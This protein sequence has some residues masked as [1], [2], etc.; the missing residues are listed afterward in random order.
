MT[1]KS[2]RSDLLRPD[3]M[4]LIAF[5]ATVFAG[6]VTFMT[7]GGFQGENVWML[8]LIVSGITFI[9]VLLGLAMLML[10]VDPADVTR[11]I[12][13]PILRDDDDDDDDDD[14]PAVGGDKTA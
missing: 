8:T 11:T 7:T 14:E 3:H 13:K 1:D 9:V 2:T 6:F 12:D 5:A 10:A 4:L